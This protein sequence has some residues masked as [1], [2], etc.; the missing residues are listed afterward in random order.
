[1][2]NGGDGDF[3]AIIVHPVER[4][5]VAYPEPV[6]LTTGELY[7]VRGVRVFEEKLWRLLRAHNRLRRALQGPS[8]PF[9]RG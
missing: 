7:R 5:V 9:F 8:W 4:P 2:T 6:A 1:M 3:L